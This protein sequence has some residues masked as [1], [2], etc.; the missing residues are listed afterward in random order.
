MSWLQCGVS[1][2]IGS[3]D[4]TN[5]PDRQQILFKGRALTVIVWC[6]I[7]QMAHAYSPWPIDKNY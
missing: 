5:Q 7:A 1:S 3:L 4:E 2:F 6:V